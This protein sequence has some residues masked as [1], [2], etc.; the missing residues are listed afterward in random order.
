MKANKMVNQQNINFMERV[1]KTKLI[2]LIPFELSSL[3][4]KLGRKSIFPFPFFLS[5]RS[6][7][8]LNEVS[9]YHS[10]FGCWQISL[11]LRLNNFKQRISSKHSL[12]FQLTGYLQKLMPCKLIN[13]MI[14]ELRT[15]QIIRSWKKKMWTNAKHHNNIY[16]LHN[17]TH[18]THIN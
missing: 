15:Q 10:T 6:K 14:Y 3:P 16:V 11:Q 18:C 7:H 8:I 4:L 13:Q 5:L 12:L 2:Y 1:Q 9:T 17:W